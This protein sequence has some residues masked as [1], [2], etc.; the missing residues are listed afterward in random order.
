MELH[1]LTTCRVFDYISGPSLVEP[2]TLQ[3]RYQLE[4]HT[5][6]ITSTYSYNTI[7]TTMI[8]RGTTTASLLGLLALCSIT[9]DA[10]LFGRRLPFV[11]NGWLASQQKQQFALESNGLSSSQILSTRGGATAP[12]EEERMDVVEELYLPGLLEASLTKKNEVRVDFYKKPSKKSPRLPRFHASHTIS[13][14]FR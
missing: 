2:A 8:H 9:A 13:H 10:N 4:T 3:H 5:N 11:N 14:F 7:I 12:A 6:H 1:T